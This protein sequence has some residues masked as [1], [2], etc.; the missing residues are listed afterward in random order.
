MG[1]LTA[2]ACGDALGAGYEFQSHPLP[3]DHSIEMKGG[4]GFAA[5]EWTD[6]SSQLVAIGQAAAKGLD[7]RSIEG[8]EEVA[9]NY[10]S[11]FDSAD[12][13]DVGVHTQEVFGTAS[14]QRGFHAWALGE[15][16]REKEEREPNSSGGNGAIMRTAPVALAFIK[17]RLPITEE[18]LLID[19]AARAQ[20]LLTHHDS[21][22][23]AL[24]SAWCLL[25]RSAINTE[26]DG[27]FKAIKDQA[28]Q[29]LDAINPEDAVRVEALLSEAEN[30]QPH[31]FK[32]NGW[33]Q[34]AVQAAWSAITTTPIQADDKEA[35]TYRAS[36]L[37][38]ALEACCRI[39][40][41][42]DTVACIAGGVLGAT[43]GLRAVPLSWRRLIHGWPGLNDR[44]LMELTARILGYRRDD[45]PFWGHFVHAENGSISS[46]TTHPHDPGVVLAAVGTLTEARQYAL[47]PAVRKALDVTAVVS[48]CRMGRVMHIRNVEAANWILVPFE[49]E[50]DST[51]PT[52]QFLVDQAADVVADLRAEG[53]RVLIHGVR[54]DLIREVAVD[55]SVRHLNRN[56]KPARQDIDTA[57]KHFEAVLTRSGP[58]DPIG[59]LRPNDSVIFKANFPNGKIFLG[60]TFE[61][62]YLQ[63]VHDGGRK[64][65]RLTRYAGTVG[66]SRSRRL[67]IEV[68]ARKEN[69]GFLEDYERWDVEAAFKEAEIL[70]RW[71]ED[72]R[73]PWSA[74]AEWVDRLQARD[75]AV[76][77]NT[78]SPTYFPPSEVAGKCVDF[79][80]T[81]EFHS[82]N[83]YLQPEATV[84]KF[85]NGYFFTYLHPGDGSF[86]P[87]LPELAIVREFISGSGDWNE[88]LP[89]IGPGD[90]FRNG[91][92]I[93]NPDFRIPP[94]SV[95][96]LL[97][98]SYKKAAL[99][100]FILPSVF[101]SEFTDPDNQLG[102]ELVGHKDVSM[103]W[104]SDYLH[105]SFFVLRR[106]GLMQGPPLPVLRHY[107]PYESLDQLARTP[108]HEVE[109][110]ERERE[111]R[112][113]RRRQ[114]RNRQ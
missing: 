55:Y 60:I 109:Y 64:L 69:P 26:E 77:Y 90:Y 103:E 7:L 17:D 96:P 21:P 15:I 108:P 12:C 71:A 37:Q 66:D 106:H 72:P 35:G 70:W 79:L 11:W 20:S 94:R 81:E 19:E 23:A 114:E 22:T 3:S 53:H 29:W 28:L 102:L 16:A 18:V 25:I 57:L 50:E 67:A 86:S 4:N 91:I 93:G 44:G 6:D 82:R 36:H 47:S 31:D 83:P 99:V 33:S 110:R 80:L 5:G 59:R 63:N 100:A 34:H 10:Q 112:A 38:R 87:H 61:E 30:S 62:S 58:R 2:S 92:V 113:H 75:P 52:W 45:W 105:L 73:S 95:G 41:D 107:P 43:W 39:H 68:E 49:T 1:V 24:A 78:V 51:S 27:D 101:L 48:L 56:V 89:E 104:G 65:Y 42:T 13:H 88:F 85:A 8:R 76:G 111:L 54:A 40:N 97:L 74:L 84:P 32:N 9:R 46:I 14:R 98:A